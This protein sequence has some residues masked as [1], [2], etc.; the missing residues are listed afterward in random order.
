MKIDDALIE[1]LADLAKLEFEGEE[2][3]QIKADLEKMLGFADKLN[4]V[5]TAGVAPLIYL[6][7][8][9]SIMRKDVA[10]NPITRAEALQNAPS[11]DSDYFKVPRVLKKG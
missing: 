10:H 7:D 9:A 11:K 1:K 4:R 2:R 6:T 3:E 5:D 8:E